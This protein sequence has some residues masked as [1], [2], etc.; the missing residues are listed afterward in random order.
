MPEKRSADPK[1]TFVYEKMPVVKLLSKQKIDLIMTAVVGQGKEHTKWSPGKA[2]YKKE[3]ILKLGKL[4]NPERLA[5]L[6]SDGV[7]KF[8]GNNV[9]LVQE[10][11]YDSNLLESY[12]EA[13]KGISLTYSDNL[14]FNVESWGQL[15]CKEMLAKSSEI[16][17]EKIDEMEKLI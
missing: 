10:K 15:S 7:F 6:C 2:H 16:L 3:P 1:C 5:S 9:E 13:D 14:L 17:L 11:V 8:K 12:A 4:Q